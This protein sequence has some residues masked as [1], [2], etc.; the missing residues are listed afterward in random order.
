[1]IVIATQRI[2]PRNDNE[3][4]LY[5]LEQTVATIPSHDQN[6]WIILLFFYSSCAKKPKEIV[7]VAL[8][9]H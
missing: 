1:M 8:K 2:L 5:L 9:E 7:K 6:Q 4:L 3:R